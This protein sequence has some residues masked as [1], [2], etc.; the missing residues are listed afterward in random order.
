[1]GL[2][3]YLKGHKNFITYT[4]L[5]GP[6]KEDGFELTEKVLQLGYWR[7]HPDLHGYIVENFAEGVDDCKPIYLSEECI[8][9]IITAIKNEELPHTEGFFF[10]RSDGSE[11]EESLKIFEDALQ[12]KRKDELYVFK[13]IY[14]QASW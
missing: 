14:Y 12:W 4:R 10:G 8:E 2:D 6:Y 1:M 5:E 11:S 7:K 3:M 9:K 13:H